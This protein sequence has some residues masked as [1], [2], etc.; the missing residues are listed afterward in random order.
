TS[1]DA[2]VDLVAATFRAPDGVLR[3]P[4]GSGD[5]TAL[6]TCVR[7]LRSSL[8]LS[9]DWPLLAAVRNA[10]EELAVRLESG[11]EE[12]A[13]TDAALRLV[14][15]W[16]QVSRANETLVGLPWRATRARRNPFVDIPASRTSEVLEMLW[17]ASRT[18][19]GAAFELLRA[20]AC[21][22]GE[23]DDAVRS[24]HAAVADRRYEGAA[25]HLASSILL[26][27][28]PWPASV[29]AAARQVAQQRAAAPPEIEGAAPDVE[30]VMTWG[31]AARRVDRGHRSPRGADA[32]RMACRRAA[33]STGSE[34]HLARIWINRVD[35]PTR[36]SRPR[37]ADVSAVVKMLSS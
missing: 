10:T 7:G 3:L 13:G 30:Q 22:R 36:G 17:V 32:F 15:L 19:T 29:A 6:E 25:R 11:A 9:P 5:R 34:Q 14:Q 1:F 26:G 24:P 27:S 23:S 35:L 21:V 20:V 37:K 33:E 4:R 18:E 16:L 28:L 2:V 8:N 12:V 31:E